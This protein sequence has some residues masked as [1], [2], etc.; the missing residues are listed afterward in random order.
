MAMRERGAVG[1]PWWLFLVTGIAWLVVSL[2]VLRFDVTSVS[3][4]GVLLGVI[5]LMA[6]ANE[7]AAMGTRQGWTWLYALMGVLFIGGGIWAI[8]NPI[9]AFYELAAILGFLLVLKGAFDISLAFMTKEVNE[10]WWLGLVVGIL[11]VL[12][13]FWV[14]QQFF[15]PRAALILLWVGFAAMFRGFGEIFLAFSVRRMHR[16]RGAV[17]V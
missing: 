13:A 5:L 6:G 11:E 2:V 17:P 4:V 12:L 8:I 16:D 9:G 1:V 15:M 3:T 7:F 14:S 10:L